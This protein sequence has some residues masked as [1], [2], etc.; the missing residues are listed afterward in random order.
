MSA[1]GSE[2][3]QEGSLLLDD[4]LCFALYA[5]SRA[6]TARYRPLLDELGLTYPQYLVMLALWEQDSISVRDLGHA[7]QLES[8]TL[9]PLLKRLEG[10]GLLR[11][12]RRAE[13][14][15]SVALR[16]TEAGAAMRDRA[17]TVPVAIG[18]AMGLTQEQDALAKQLLRLL[19]VNVSSS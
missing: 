9:S 15:R 6:V 4:Q 13:D 17:H 11:R 8:S 12:E 16:L 14:E 1:A 2:P 5:A 10:N 7:L 3:P 19:T 18:D